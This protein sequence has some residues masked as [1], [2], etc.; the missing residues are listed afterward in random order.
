[1]DRGQDGIENEYDKIDTK[2]CCDTRGH[3]NRK[4]GPE[5]NMR[6]WW[7]K[8]ISDEWLILPLLISSLLIYI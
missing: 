8:V 6:D 5:W 2:G 7:R 1:M 4:W 3:G